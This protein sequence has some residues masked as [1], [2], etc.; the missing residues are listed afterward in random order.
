MYFLKE[1]FPNEYKK[2]GAE[3]KETVE[4]IIEKVK[5]WEKDYA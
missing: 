4:E 1:D 2:M 3:L 5:Q